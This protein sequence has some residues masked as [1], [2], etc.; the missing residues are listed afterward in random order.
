MTPDR[1]LVPIVVR[2]ATIIDV[3]EM[4]WLAERR[5][6]RASGDAA[7]GT[8]QVPALRY[9]RSSWADLHEGAVAGAQAQLA[10][11]DAGGE[12]LV[13]Q[14]ELGENRNGRRQN[15]DADTKLADTAC[16]LG[17]DGGMADGVERQR[18][19]EPADAAADNDDARGAWP[20]GGLADHFVATPP[21]GHPL[22]V[23]H[24]V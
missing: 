14:F 2:P 20:V 21:G 18:D 17:H 15:V 9:E 1:R 13:E 6:I 4:T 16:L 12:Q 24:G 5:P 23:I 11:S 19:G 10:G 22:A 3:D 7:N 8:L